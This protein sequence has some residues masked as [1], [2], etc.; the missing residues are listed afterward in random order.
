M[1]VESNAEA[2]ADELVMGFR[3]RSCT[4]GVEIATTQ[5]GRHS[6][7][8]GGAVYALLRKI[9]PEAS[10][11]SVAKALG[12]FQGVRQRFE[13]VAP[14][15]GGH[16]AIVNDY[17]HNPEKVA[18]AIG[19]AHERFGGPLGVVF[20]PHGFSA[21]AFTREPLLEHLKQCLGTDDL[22]LMLPVYYA[23]GTAAFTPTSQEV[24]AQYAE[25]GLPVRFVA[26]RPAAAALLKARHDLKAWLVLGGRDAS[27]RAW[28]LQLARRPG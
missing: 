1:P 9:L 3:V 12:A 5:S 20:Q 7:W 22:F 15:A 6:A 8:N 13:V 16:P 2:S 11:A 18:A 14:Q 23:G 10:P 27:L 21:L 25:A 19:A 17:A 4:D 28:S 26:D 24:A